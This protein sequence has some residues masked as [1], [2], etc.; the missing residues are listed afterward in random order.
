MTKLGFLVDN[1]GASQLGYYV[2]KNVGTYLEDHPQSNITCYYD[3]F[4]RKCSQT[5]FALTYILT[6]FFVSKF[7]GFLSICI[8]F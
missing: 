6:F 8:F 2:S 7:L 4:E 3:N 1:L 5:N